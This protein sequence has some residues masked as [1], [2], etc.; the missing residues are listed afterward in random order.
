MTCDVAC[1]LQISRNNILFLPTVL[2]VSLVLRIIPIFLS[3]ASKEI[4][5]AIMPY[6]V[7]FIS[8]NSSLTF[9]LLDYSN[10]IRNVRGTRVCKLLLLTCLHSAEIF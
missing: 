2:P 4:N 8:F 10:Q 3:L 7:G 5:S 9:I 1:S 6:G